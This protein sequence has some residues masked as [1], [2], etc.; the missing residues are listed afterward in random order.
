MIALAVALIGV[1]I[2][3]GAA[4]FQQVNHQVPVLMVTRAV[5]A[6]TVVRASDLGT[7][8]VVLSGGVKA[9]PSGQEHQVVRPGRGHQPAAGHAAGPGRAD[10][11][12]AA[13]VAASSSCPSR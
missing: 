6:G 1:G 13:V 8:S 7:T 3:G 12:A 5:P 11:H 9:I 10:H 2:L 4:L